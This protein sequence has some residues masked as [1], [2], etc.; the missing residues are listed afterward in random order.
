MMPVP[1][2]QVEKLLK[3]TTKYPM[4]FKSRND[5]QRHADSS[6]HK[7]NDPTFAVMIFQCCQKYIYFCNFSSRLVTLFVQSLMDT[8]VKFLQ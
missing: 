5:I 4:P 3:D 8:F 7:Q 1:K 6:E 2:T